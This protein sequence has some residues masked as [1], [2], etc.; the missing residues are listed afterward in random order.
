MENLE[1]QLAKQITQEIVSVSHLLAAGNSPAFITLVEMYL[2]KR[3]Q[4]HK[5]Q[6]FDDI[7]NT[8]IL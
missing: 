5:Q 1:K 6:I 7:I 4:D 3:L 8:A 2:E